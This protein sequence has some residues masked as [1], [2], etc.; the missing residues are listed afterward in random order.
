M[1]K[2][3]SLLTKEIQE[4]LKTSW[5]DQGER[6]EQAQEE[7]CL[8]GLEMSRALCISDK[9]YREVTA[10]KSGLSATARNRLFE[11]LKINPIWFA[12][13]EGDM[14]YKKGQAVREKEEKSK[15]EQQVNRLLKQFSEFSQMPEEDVFGIEVNPT[16]YVDGEGA[17]FFEKENCPGDTEQFEMLFKKFNKLA[18]KG[19]LSDE[20]VLALIS[21]FLTV[22]G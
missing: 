22:R 8:C 7:L 16:W 10:G 18:E 5:L 11:K 14:F 1:P 6:L 9:T 2:T 3:N 13:G 15:A 19:G 20:Q 17:M 12:Y 21:R 4:K